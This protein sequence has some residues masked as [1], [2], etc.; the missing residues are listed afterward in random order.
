MSDSSLISDNAQNKSIID[1]CAMGVFVV[2]GMPPI[3]TSW[4]R[5][6]AEKSQH[7]LENATGQPLHKLFP[8]YPGSPLEQAISNTITKNNNSVLTLAPGQSPLSLQQHNSAKLGFTQHIVISPIN[9][10]PGK[11]SALIQVFDISCTTTVESKISNHSEEAVLL[12]AGNQFDTSTLELMIKQPHQGI[13]IIDDKENIVFFNRTGRDIFEISDQ[14]ATK[15]E[16]SK[17]FAQPENQFFCERIKQ[18]KTS[19][20]TKTFIPYLVNSVSLAD[21]PLK[22]E[23]IAASISLGTSRHRIII[24]RDLTDLIKAEE[25]LHHEKELVEVTLNSITEAVITT[26]KSGHIQ[27]MNRVAE[28]LTGWS[29]SEAINCFLYDVYNAYDEKSGTVINNPITICIKDGNELLSQ[30]NARTVLLDK[31]TNNLYGIRETAAPIC[32]SDG[33]IIGCVLIFHDETNERKLSIKLHW[34]S[35][36]D[37]LTGLYNRNEFEKRLKISLT[38]TGMEAPNHAVLFLDLDQFKII[39]DTAGHNAGDLM[40]RQLANEIQLC[41]RDSDTCA[42]LGGDEFGIILNHCDLDSALTVAHN[43]RETIEQFLFS[44]NE[45]LFKVGVSIGIVLADKS[46]SDFGQLLSAADMACNTA[47]EQGRNQVH[48]YQFDDNESANQQGQMEWVSKIH[49]AIENNRFELYAQLIKAINH[50][51]ADD[52][53]HYEILLRLVD[54]SGICIPPGAFIPAA[55]RFNIMSKVDAWVV[56]EVFS[57]CKQLVNNGHQQLKLSVNLSGA[58]LIDDTFLDVL[59]SVISSFPEASNHII[60]EITETT[61]ILR[62]DKATQ[63]ISRFQQQGF[64]FSLDDFGSGLSSFGYLKKLKV[65]YLKIDGMFVKD[66]IEDNID[67]AMVEAIN[68]I[69]H[70][71]GI[72]TIAEF[73]E[74]AEILAALEEIGVDFAQGYG[75]HKPQPLRE[76]FPYYQPNLRVNA[77]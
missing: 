13:L 42:R 23:A 5:W 67:H 71:M 30:P 11:D 17:L 21:K 48:V 55:E 49:K 18:T 25:L 65:N 53:E 68:E 59:D 54:E 74:D 61:A 3:V 26:N 38:Q 50:Q 47:K 75:I 36:H 69:G 63:F 28:K 1:A 73:V 20:L 40:L 60:F 52:G 7:S 32:N 41:V 6:M 66:M 34:Q 29:K 14:H 9:N 70:V 37:Q 12:T 44:W 2:S 33:E 16:L 10:T 27:Y 8:E 72:Q 57:S 76:L 31:N 64:Q 22:L 58:S 19:N 77:D 35:V 43:I 4:N 62:M 46:H 24:F 51:T 45:H 56:K 15:T 39:N